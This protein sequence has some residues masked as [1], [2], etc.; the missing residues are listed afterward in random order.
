M[1]R[2]HGYFT[3]LPALQ[4]G[5]K[6]S[7][8]A[9]CVKYR[10]RRA[11]RAKESILLIIHTMLSRLARPPDLTSRWRVKEGEHGPPIIQYAIIPAF[12]SSMTKRK[13]DRDFHPGRVSVFLSEL[14]RCVGILQSVCPMKG[15]VDCRPHHQ[16]G[17]HRHRSF[18]PN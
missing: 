16:W 9:L 6:A 14:P 2:R 18:P 4:A 8:K 13:P 11:R 5:R 1:K 15:Q 3:I 7:G 17:R 10:T 12:H